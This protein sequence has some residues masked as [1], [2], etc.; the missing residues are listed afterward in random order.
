[1]NSPMQ[2]FICI[3]VIKSCILPNQTLKMVLV[4][5]VLAD[6]TDALSQVSYLQD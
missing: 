2:L 5:S 4:I 6:Q 3:N 1:M